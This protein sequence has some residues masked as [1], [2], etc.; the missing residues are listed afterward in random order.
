MEINR[1]R[2][3]TCAQW[4]AILSLF[5]AD[6]VPAISQQRTQVLIQVPLIQIKIRE[7]RDG[8]LGINVS[9]GQF[10]SPVEVDDEGYAL[11]AD[12]LGEF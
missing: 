11:L 4:I 1:V 12:V 6:C 8:Q 7:R 5:P 3:L 9:G 10:D 2:Q